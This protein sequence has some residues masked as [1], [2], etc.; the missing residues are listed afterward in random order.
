[1]VIF[2][3]HCLSTSLPKWGTFQ[4][5]RLWFL[6]RNSIKSLLLEWLCFLTVSKGTRREKFSVPKWE[7]R[8]AF[9]RA[10]VYRW[11]TQSQSPWR[12]TC[13]KGNKD[14]SYVAHKPCSH[15]C[16]GGLWHWKRKEMILPL[17]LQQEGSLATC[18]FIVDFCSQFH[19][20]V[21]L[22][23]LKDIITFNII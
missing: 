6:W 12:R 15:S 4:I 7:I 19:Y 22:E 13:V 18:C 10:L 11:R 2:G 23:G 1:M 20:P 17:I 9:V 16:G 8:T 14:L 5:L 3:G 21:Y